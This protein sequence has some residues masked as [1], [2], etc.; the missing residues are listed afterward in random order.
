MIDNLDQKK[1]L[2]IMASTWNNPYY[3]RDWQKSGKPKATFSAYFSNGIYGDDTGYA[4]A[5]IK[6]GDL[7]IDWKSE[8]M[9]I[10][11]AARLAELLAQRM[12]RLY[13]LSDDAL[14]EAMLKHPR[15]TVDWHSN[16]TQL[17]GQSCPECGG[18][19]GHYVARTPYG[20]AH[21]ILEDKGYRVSFLS[22]IIHNASHK[23]AK[24]FILDKVR[25]WHRADCCQVVGV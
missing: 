24:Q 4:S 1:S 25:A 18:L 10:S 19:Q 11:R 9:R 16:I 21:L 22:E 13:H 15:L 3:W 2:D 23:Q 17:A 6:R 20:E 12:N 5:Q 7:S 14:L 8:Y